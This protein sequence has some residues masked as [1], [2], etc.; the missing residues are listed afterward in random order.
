MPASRFPSSRF[1]PASIGLL[2]VATA[3]AVGL[4]ADVSK[5][6][7]AANHKVDFARDVQ[8]I[9]AKHCVSCHGPEKQKSDYR[10]DVRAFALKAGSIGGAIVP[11]D[12]GKSLLLQYV[13]GT[14]ADIRMPPKGKMLSDEQVGVLRAWIDQGAP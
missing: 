12:A 10:L 4:A 13:A 14:H 3:V 11:G 7:P 9:F 2:T 5:P 8:P 6:P 1:I